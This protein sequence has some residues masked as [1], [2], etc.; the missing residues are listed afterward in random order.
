[1]STHKLYLTWDEFERHTKALCHRIKQTPEYKRGDYKGILVITRGGLAPASVIATELN[2]RLIETMCIVSYASDGVKLEA[3]I[4]MEADI[5]KKPNIDN[6]GQGWLVVDDLVDT[7]KT[8]DVIREI[9]PKA[10]YIT[11]Y[12]KT[13]GRPKTDMCMIEIPQETWIVLPWEER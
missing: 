4:Q 1:M 13:E 2:I 8:F 12:A 7:G 5:I 10:F 6:D 11:I 9:L 3:D